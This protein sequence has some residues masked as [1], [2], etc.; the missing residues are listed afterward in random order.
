MSERHG[1]PNNA[2]ALSRLVTQVAE[3]YTITERL[4]AYNLLL[5]EAIMELGPLDD[6]QIERAIKAF[7]TCLRSGKDIFGKGEW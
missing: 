4:T 1:D 3:H 2:F 7:E 5:T 6:E